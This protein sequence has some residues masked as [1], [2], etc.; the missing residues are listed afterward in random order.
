[1]TPARKY[2]LQDLQHT[3]RKYHFPLYRK[4]SVC[5]CWQLAQA[6]PV[7]QLP[8][9]IKNK[10]Q[11]RGFQYRSTEKPN[12]LWL[13]VCHV[14]SQ[15][16]I[17]SASWYLRLLQFSFYCFVCL[18]S[19]FLIVGGLHSISICTRMSVSNSDT[20]IRLPSWLIL[21]HA[22]GRDSAALI[23]VVRRQSLIASQA[24]ACLLGWFFSTL[25]ETVVLSEDS[26]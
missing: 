10:I 17:L 13:I 26:H 23:S 3:R 7:P 25:S 2:L 12:S 14:T 20:S 19:F 8:E 22:V 21:L 11:H 24:F 5:L 15:S 4:N 16:H 9:L 18:F 6:L 1:M